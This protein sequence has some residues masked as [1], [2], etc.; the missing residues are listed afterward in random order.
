MTELY[1]V[2]DRNKLFKAVEKQLKALVPQVKRK[3]TLGLNERLLNDLLNS[4]LRC[5]SFNERQKFYLHIAVGHNAK[6]FMPFSSACWPFDVMIRK[7]GA[8]EPQVLV[9]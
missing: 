5:P 1:T 2:A 9:R 7:P 4:G 3:Q 6:F 8:T